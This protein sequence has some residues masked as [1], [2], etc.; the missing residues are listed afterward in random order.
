MT[1]FSALE[2]YMLEQFNVM[3]AQVRV[4]PLASNSIDDAEVFNQ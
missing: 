1:R 3:C 4:Q 2:Q